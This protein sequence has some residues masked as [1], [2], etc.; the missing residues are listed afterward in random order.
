LGKHAVKTLFR[1]KFRLA[2][3]RQLVHEP[4]PGVMPREAVLVTRITESD[5]ELDSGHLGFPRIT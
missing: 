3:A 4:E 1:A 5:D 2:T